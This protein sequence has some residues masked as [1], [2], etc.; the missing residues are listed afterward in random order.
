MP[1]AE[2]T[3]IDPSPAALRPDGSPRSYTVRTLGCQ[4][5]VHDS[6]RLSGSL[7]AAGYIAAESPDSADVYVINTCAVRENAANKLYGNLGMLA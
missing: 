4:M 3:L 1:S 2:A 7:E 6:E 5:N